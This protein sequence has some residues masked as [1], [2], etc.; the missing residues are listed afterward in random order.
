MF[1]Q[2]VQERGF[3]VSESC[4]SHPLIHLLLPAIPVSFF[5]SL[6]FFPLVL[7]GRVRRKLQMGF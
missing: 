4:L 5:L 3:I 1:V 6:F 7:R 2:A